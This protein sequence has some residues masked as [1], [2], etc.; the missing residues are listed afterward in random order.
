M[1]IL[2]VCQKSQHFNICITF[3]SSFL[4]IY[5]NPVYAPFTFLACHFNYY[6]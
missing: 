6:I 2:K 3:A 5:Y 4:A 1:L